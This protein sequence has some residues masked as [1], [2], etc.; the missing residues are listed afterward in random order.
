[1]STPAVVQFEITGA[2]SANLQRFYGSL[3][4]WQANPTGTPGYARIL[5]SQSGIPGAIGP[6]WD[7][8]RGQLTV[9]VEV[10]DLQQTLAHAEQ[11]GGR[12]IGAPSE[13]ARRVKRV[14]QWSPELRAHVVPGAGISFSFVADPEGHVVAVSQGLEPALGQFAAR[15]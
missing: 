14:A 15:H 11:L 13:D 6:S 7:G 1:M 4:G 3:F 10:P 9:Y 8:G 2:D 12:V 5:G